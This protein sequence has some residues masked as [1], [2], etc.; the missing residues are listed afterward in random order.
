MTE[1]PRTVALVGGTGRL[2]RALRR[3][4]SAAGIPSRALARSPTPEPEVRAGDR[5]DPTTLRTFLDGADLA[6]DLCAFDAADAEA[7]LAAWRACERPPNR[8]LFVSALA[9]RP[10]ERWRDALPTDADALEAALSAAPPTDA[11]GR[12]KRTARQAFRDALGDRCRTALLPQLFAPDDLDARE[13]RYLR[14]ARD[15]GSVQLPGTGEQVPCVLHVDLAAQALC[16]YLQRPDAPPVLQIAPPPG[17]T[18]IT[19]VRALLAGAGVTATLAPNRS[20][21]G[22]H[23]AGSERV[24]AAGARSLLAAL[25][26]HTHSAQLVAAHRDLGARF[27]GET[28]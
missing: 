18:V 2:G 11:Y 15:T 6:V 19:L 12:G 1:P 16:A 13:L 22:P 23:S 26:W 20:E 7:L 24:D 14:D 8:L 25:P 28:G 4:L 21:R 17:P 5:H 3:A 10:A 27:S 9:E